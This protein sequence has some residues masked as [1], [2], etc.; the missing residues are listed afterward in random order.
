MFWIAAG[1]IY[2]VLILFFWCIV[3]VGAKAERRFY[4]D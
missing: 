1:I 4:D 2:L 3:A